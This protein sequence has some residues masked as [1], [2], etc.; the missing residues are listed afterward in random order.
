[1]GETYSTRPSEI[2]GIS[3]AYTAFCL[4]EALFLRLARERQD[5]EREEVG[6]RRQLAA[7]TLADGS[8]VTWE[9]GEP[10]PAAVLSLVP[11]E[12]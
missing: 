12:R 11:M 9:P 1:M 7:A 10:P 3:D 6:E 5:A 4:D 8:R 2:L